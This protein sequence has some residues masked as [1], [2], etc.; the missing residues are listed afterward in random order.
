MEPRVSFITLAGA[1]V[2]PAEDR[3]WGGYSGCSADHDRY[4]W[5][6]AWNPHPIGQLVLPEVES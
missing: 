3:E 2:K 4:R 1:E 6:V 5:E